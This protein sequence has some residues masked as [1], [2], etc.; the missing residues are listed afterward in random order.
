MNSHDLVICSVQANRTSY[1]VYHSVHD[2]FYWMSNFGDPTFSQHLAA[3][4]IWIKLALIL[5]TDPILPFD[6]RDYAVAIEDIFHKLQ[7][8]S[9]DVLSEQGISLCKKL[10]WL[11][12]PIPPL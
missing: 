7:N 8:S 9:G 4:L 1:G 11:P 10:A 6:P 3:G 2:N 5:S 12:R